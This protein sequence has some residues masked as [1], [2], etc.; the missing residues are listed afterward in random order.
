MRI[1]LLRFFKT[2]QQHLND[3]L[4]Y[5]VKSFTILSRHTVRNQTCIKDYKNFAFKLPK[6]ANF[7]KL[8]ICEFGVFCPF[9]QVSL[10]LC[11]CIALNTCYVVSIL[12]KSFHLQYSKIIRFLAKRELNW[13]NFS[14][15][16][17]EQTDK[18]WA[19][20]QKTDMYLKKNHMGTLYKNK[21]SNKSPT[22]HI[23]REMEL[24]FWWK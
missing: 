23:F 18:N 14:Y 15:F 20:F 11:N 13:R 19:Q 6:H 9:L 22:S 2:L 10:D 7:D 24:V 17:N 4:H 16:V 12:S 8:Q 1:S 5:I 21:V 3:S